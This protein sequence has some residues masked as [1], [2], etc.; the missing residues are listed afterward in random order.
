MQIAMLKDAQAQSLQPHFIPLIAA[1]VGAALT[2]LQRHKAAKAGEG[3]Q[4]TMLTN[5][6]KQN[7]WQQKQ[8]SPFAPFSSLAKGQI[9]AAFA[10]SR[11]MDKIFGDKFLDYISDAGNVP[12]TAGIGGQGD[13]PLPKFDKVKSGSSGLLTIGAGVAPVVGAAFSGIGQSEPGTTG[14]CGG[15]GL[16]HPISP[17]DEEPQT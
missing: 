15:G 9:L 10:R 7:L 6:M 14:V 5:Q 16:L 1:G 3:A 12:G 4:G 8:F 11:G 2:A 13:V 17:Y